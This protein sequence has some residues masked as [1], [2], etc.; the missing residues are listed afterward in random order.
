MGR[1]A[2]MEKRQK[3]MDQAQQLINDGKIDEA[4]A[5]MEDVKK[6]DAE[7]ENVAKATANMQTL[8][9][10]QPK[11]NLQNLTDANAVANLSGG[12]MTAGKITMNGLNGEED[13]KIDHASDVY[14]NA[15]AKTMQRKELSATEAETYKMVNV[16]FAHTTGNTGTV[17]PKSVESGIWKE[18]GE[19]YPYWND[20]R[21]TYVNGILSM[22]MGDTSTDAK[23]YEEAEAVEDG[24]ETFGTLTLNGCELARSVTVSWKLQEMAMDEF[25]PYMQSRLAEKMGAALGYGVTHGKGQPGSSDTFKQEPTGVVTALEAQE[26][27]PQVV[28]YTKDA[29]S[30]DDIVNARAKIKGGYANGLSVYANADTIWTQIAKVKDKNERPI[31]ITDV[32]NGTGV[33]RVLGC[34]VKEDDSMKDGEILFSNAQRG[35]TANVNKEMTVTTEQHVKQRETDYCGYAI[36][37]GNIITAKAHALLKQGE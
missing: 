21:K 37:D 29:L 23:W 16:A 3:L 12:Q 11:M 9:D 31:F 33:G 19:L 7:F 5:V 20:I 15:W 1:K 14:L 30:Y 32:Q 17:I 27:T 22:V 34:V 8:S 13:K 6:L 28:T 26:T 2:Y 18:V 24:K 36:V 4:N 10:A 35:Y 25:L